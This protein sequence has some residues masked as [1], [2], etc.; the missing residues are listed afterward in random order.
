M[1]VC[2]LF[3]DGFSVGVSF[4]NGKNDRISSLDLIGAGSMDIHIFSRH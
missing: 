4:C 2:F 3:R 1:D